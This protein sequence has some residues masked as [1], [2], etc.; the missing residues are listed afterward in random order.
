MVNSNYLD[1]HDWLITEQIK[2]EKGEPIEFDNHP[3]LF[4]IYSD[5]AQNL[6][7]MKAAQVGLTT[8][9]MLKNHFDAKQ[10]RIDI[11]YT[12]PTDSDV[13]VMVGGKL[14]RIIANNPCLFPS[15]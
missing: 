8:A 5:N 6:V 3:F 15:T 2:N 4:D 7:I 10:K 13:K 11:L 9:E 14:N 1:I 12:L